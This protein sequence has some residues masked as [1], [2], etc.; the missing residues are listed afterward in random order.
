M[1]IVES[2]GPWIAPDT[3][4]PDRVARHA[5]ARLY[6]EER[7]APEDAAHSDHAI[8]G[9]NPDPAL[10]ATARPAAVLIP[11]VARPDGATLLLTRRTA[12]LRQHSGQIAFPGGKIDAGEDALTA[13]LRETEEEIGLPRSRVAPLGFLG[14]YFSTTGF[15]IT[16]VVAVIAPD[17]PLALNADEVD[18][19]FEAP[20][21][22]LMDPANHRID[23]R[24]WKGLM[25]SYFAMPH[26]EHYIWGVTAGI[27]RMLWLRLYA[28][29]DR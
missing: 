17:E 4:L 15:R 10:L 2:A 21:S 24:E 11:I 20:L 25:R 13:A 14:P 12:N 1:S 5:A 27:I 9:M 6:A 23:Q 22:F 18:A 8:A 7:L 19:V 26:G 16:P 3:Y 29:H 28:P